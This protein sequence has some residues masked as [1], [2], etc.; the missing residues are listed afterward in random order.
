MKTLPDQPVEGQ[1]VRREVGGDFFRRVENRGRTN[2]LVSILDF[3]F[4]FEETRLLEG[5]IRAEMRADQV[6]GLECGFHGDA[7][8]IGAHI[9]D[10]TDRFAGTQFD[11]FIE[12][13]GDEHG[14]LG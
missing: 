8:R 3:L 13:L 12:L 2:G 1:L 9:G 14:L 11:P 10:Q 6:K 5:I 7:G 4:V